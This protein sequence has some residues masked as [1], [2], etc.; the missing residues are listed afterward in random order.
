MS[1]D[2]YFSD[3][4]LARMSTRMP[5]S[6]VTEFEAMLL[7]LA[8]LI[9]DW[10]GNARLAAIAARSG[11]GDLFTAEY[12]RG[13]ARAYEEVSEALRLAVMAKQKERA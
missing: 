6:L 12:A 8:E 5:E 13:Y 2:V 1:D 4:L 7:D 9:S 10:A 3:A 11:D